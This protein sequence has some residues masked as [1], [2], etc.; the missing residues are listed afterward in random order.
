MSGVRKALVLGAFALASCGQ[1][2]ANTYPPQY[3]LNFMRACQAQGPGLQSLCT[4]TWEKI[5]REIPPDDFAAFE[6][7]PANE[8]TTHP[9]RERIERYAL[10]CRQQTDPAPEDPPEP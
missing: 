7:L 5:E 2:A 3:E 9:M 10:V 6:R 1:Q 8:Q 4:C